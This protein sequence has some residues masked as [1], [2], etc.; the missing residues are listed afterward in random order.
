MHATAYADKLRQLETL[1]LYSPL[2]GVPRCT[3]KSYQ[4]LR[5][6]DQDYTLPPQ[7]GVFVNNTALQC[8]QEYWGPDGTLWRPDRWVKREA[9]LEIVLNPIEGTFVPWISGPRVCPGKKFSQVEFVAVIASLLKDHRAR[10]VLMGGESQ[11]EAYERTLK[12]VKDSNM[13]VAV[14]MNHPERLRLKW[15]KKRDL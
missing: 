11:T 4:H 15:V 7:T 8:K 1:R 14:Q 10:P 6:N 12:V 13:K 5:I 9:D 3:G 2:N